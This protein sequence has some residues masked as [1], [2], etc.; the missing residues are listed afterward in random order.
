MPPRSALTLSI[1]ICLALTALDAS[2]QNTPRNRRP[3]PTHADLRYGAHERNV[4]DL[5]LLESD[6]PTPLVVYIHGGGFRGGDK[7][8]VSPGLIRE[9]HVRGM[10][11]ASINYPLT[12]TAHFPVQFHDPARALQFIRHHARTYNLD[13]M[14]IGLTGG[15]AGA[16]ISL[17]LAFHDDLAVQDSSDPIARQSTRVQAVAVSGAQTSYD[18]HW[19]M[20][21][22]GGVSYLNSA[23]PPL[24][25][26]SREEWDT[27]HALTVFKELGAINHLTADDPPV[28]MIYRVPNRPLTKDSS[29]SDSIHHPAFGHALRKQMWE[30]GVHC[31]VLQT[32]DVPG[33]QDGVWPRAQMDKRIA[34]FMAKRLTD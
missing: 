33:G 24:W 8:G 5:Y 21:H 4:I 20:K 12:D 23:L 7:S 17:W 32:T 30:L 14:R 2:A 3:Q 25:G 19:M 22:V 1:T 13:P 18:P 15:S 26:F 6:T 28:W 9:C 10:S 11:V 16:G 29:H 27:P 31:T 34:A